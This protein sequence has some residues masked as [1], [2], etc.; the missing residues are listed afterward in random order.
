MSLRSVNPLRA[1][2]IPI[3]S[4]TIMEGKPEKDGRRLCRTV[5]KDPYVILPQENLR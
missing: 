4:V 3:C 2:E 5:R 1:K